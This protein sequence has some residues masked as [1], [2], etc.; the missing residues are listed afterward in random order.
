MLSLWQLAHCAANNT[1][2]LAASPPISTPPEEL[3]ED[4]LLEDDELELDDELLELDDELELLELLELLEDELDELDEEPTGGTSVPVPPQA[5]STA[6]PTAKA[7]KRLP[8]T[9]ECFSAS[10]LSEAP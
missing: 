8:E 2:P 5:L 9:S 6:A 10:D 7:N 3:E 1:A 4:E